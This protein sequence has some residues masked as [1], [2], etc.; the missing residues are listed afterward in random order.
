MGE[1]SKRREYGQMTDVQMG[2]L[3]WAT[4]N[5][6]FLDDKGLY[7][8]APHLK[9]GTPE[10]DD[11]V[12]S[13]P[14]APTLA[15]LVPRGFVA[16]TL[17]QRVGPTAKGRHK[18]ALHLRRPE[19]R[20]PYYLPASEIQ[21]G[22]LIDLGFDPVAVPDRDAPNVYESEFSRVLDPADDPSVMP[23]NWSDGEVPLWIETGAD[24]VIIF[25]AGHLIRQVGE[26]IGDR[27]TTW[28]GA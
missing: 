28:D 17:G 24:D 15:T 12:S 25:P 5:P 20:I 14:K 1:E 11:V 7:V 21:P 6:V 13:R 3:M 27:V 22:A 9:P 23:L 4:Q 10:F 8:P 19:N 26:V 16:N 18:L 2:A